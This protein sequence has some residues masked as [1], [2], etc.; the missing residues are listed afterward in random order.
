[1]NFSTT[2]LRSPAGVFGVIVPTTLD[3][4]KIIISRTSDIRQ[5]LQEYRQCLARHGH[6]DFLTVDADSKP[7]RPD[8]EFARRDIG[9][10]EEGDARRIDNFNRLDRYWKASANVCIPAFLVMMEDDLLNEMKILNPR[11]IYEATQANL[12]VMMRIL[13]E[14][15]GGWTETKGEINW[16]AMM[17]V[18]DFVDEKSV[19]KAFEI[20]KER[21][22]ERVGWNDPA[23]VYGDNF[24]KKMLTNRMCQWDVLQHLKNSFEDDDEITYDACVVRIM[25]KLAKEKEKAL[26]VRSRL[27]PMTA[28]TVGIPVTPP[29]YPMDQAAFQYECNFAE[30]NIQEQPMQASAATGY[31]RQRDPRGPKC[32]KCGQYGHISYDCVVPTSR[33]AYPRAQPPVSRL[34]IPPSFGQQPYLAS[35]HVSQQ[36]IQ[37]F[38]AYQ[39]QQ[40]LQWQQQQQQQAPP[41]RTPVVPPRSV[42]PSASDLGK[43][44]FPVVPQY[45][46]PPAKRVA[47]PSPVQYQGTL[48]LQ[49]QHEEEQ[50]NDSHNMVEYEQ[51]MAYATMY[52][53]PEY[54]S[55]EGEVSQ[56][57]AEA[58]NV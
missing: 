39:Q 42:L 41:S 15:Y 12:L 6:G 49:Q 4:K 46:R 35:K 16:M 44:P 32:Y 7:I 33:T 3:N 36:Q 43:R 58:G 40:F 20:W 9:D 27:Y 54:A 22:L 2:D 24:Y 52:S 19:L 55:G 23:Q 29:A 17:E 8:A 10:E 11:S 50:A 25:R 56:E 5:K 1:M 53:E 28:N 30:L 57:E 47:F 13:L 26:T 14:H 31:P 45:A 18:K 37:Q 51:M 38:H 34:P 48:A 21:R